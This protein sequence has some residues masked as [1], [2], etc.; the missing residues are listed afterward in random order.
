VVACLGY[1][2]AGAGALV[3]SKPDLLAGIRRCLWQLGG[4]PQ[5]L[6]WDRQA[7]VHGHDGRPSEQFAALG[8]QLRVGWHFCRPRDPQ[9]KSMV[10]RCQGYAETHF[11]PGRMFAHELDFQ[12]QLEAW[13]IKGQT[14]RAPHDPRAP[15]DRLV[16]ELKVMAPLP[17]TVPDTDRRWML[18]VAPDPYVRFDSCDYS[19]DH[20]LVGRVEVRVSDR[21]ITA[22]AL[23][24]GQLA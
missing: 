15:C 1:S 20:D 14:P 21:E 24:T 13:A 4:L 23:D 11:E 5:T 10:E 22:V 7:G 8:G 18:R 9:A 12:A 19:L 6:V 17:E 3:F 2:R 16:E